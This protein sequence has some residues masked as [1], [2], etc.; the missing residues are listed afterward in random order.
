MGLGV[1]G[2]YVWC[3]VIVIMDLGNQRGGR[4]FKVIIWSGNANHKRVGEGG[5][6]GVQVFMGKRVLCCI[7][8]LL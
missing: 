2:N 6:E 3:L 4:R 1:E 8:T 5:R 7:E